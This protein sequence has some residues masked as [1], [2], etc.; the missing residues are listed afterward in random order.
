V[1]NM[2]PTPCEKYLRGK[3]QAFEVLFFNIDCRKLY[4]DKV[5]Y[6]GYSICYVT[7]QLE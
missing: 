4:N 6:L 3:L 7:Y 2:G 1:L 5:E